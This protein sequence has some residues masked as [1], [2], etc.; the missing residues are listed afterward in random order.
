[1]AG[2]PFCASYASTILAL[3][4]C[5]ATGASNDAGGEDSKSYDVGAWLG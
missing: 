1:M 5:S 2:V 4:A 3:V